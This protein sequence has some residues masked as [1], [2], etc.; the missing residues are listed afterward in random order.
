MQYED[1]TLESNNFWIF[2]GLGFASKIIP[3]TETVSM[4]TKDNS[5]K[6]T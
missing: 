1:Q 3:Q 5:C 6:T 4:F 2:N